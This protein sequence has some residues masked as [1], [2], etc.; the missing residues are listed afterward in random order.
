MSKWTD[1]R[2]SIEQA[3][4]G[5]QI[6]EQVKQAVTQKCYDVLLPSLQKLGDGFV[7]SVK[8]Q[9]AD[10]TGWCK[11]RD[12]I[13]LPALIE[14]GLWLIEMVLKKTIEKTTIISAS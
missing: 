9:S 5:M 12:A 2:D 14:G 3:V 1:I 8:A 11:V 6:D 13:V 4:S 10:E 7:A